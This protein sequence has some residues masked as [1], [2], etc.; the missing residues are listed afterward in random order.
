MPVWYAIVHFLGID[1]GLPYGDWSFYNF[2]S[3]VAGSFAVNLITFSA[4]LWWHSTCH[5]SWH[6]LRPGRHPA[7]GGTFRL[8]WR[9]HPD[10]GV[11][12]HPAMI[13]RL[14]AEWK[15]NRVPAPGRG[16]EGREP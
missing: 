5:Y 1:A 6:C 11:R 12:P 9:H 7:A 14:H 15:A 16:V 10:M 13:N 3:G 4:V 2:W 8:C